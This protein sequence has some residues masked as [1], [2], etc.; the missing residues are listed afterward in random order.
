[1]LL[2]YRQRGGARRA[3]HQSQRQG[4][5]DQEAAEYL[6]QPPDPAA[7]EALPE[8]SVSC[9]AGA[10]RARSQLRNYTDSG[11]C[12]SVSPLTFYKYCINRMVLYV[13][14]YKLSIRSKH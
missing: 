3:D 8:N 7:G 1:M 9:A 10:G 5:E 14:M 4:E 13:I 2:Y 11:W 6:L 12:H